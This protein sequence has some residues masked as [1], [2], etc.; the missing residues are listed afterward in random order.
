MGWYGVISSR[1]G[2]G[3]G[4]R[5]GELPR[6]KEKELYRFKPRGFLC[7]CLDAGVSAHA[8][9]VAREVEAAHQSAPPAVCTEIA[10]WQRI[11][12]YVSRYVP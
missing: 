6:A 11:M 12:S 2:D 1:D 7:G 3:M 4:R 5:V 10:S 8:G 9:R